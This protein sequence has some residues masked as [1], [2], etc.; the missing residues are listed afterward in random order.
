MSLQASLSHL[1]DIKSKSAKRVKLILKSADWNLLKAIS[2][3]AFNIVQGN[4]DLTTSF[5]R[6]LKK[7]ARI[8]N[9]LGDTRVSLAVKKKLLSSTRQ[10]S[11]ILK[12]MIKSVKWLNE[13]L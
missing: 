8:I 7:Y 2:E 12:L 11:T 9:R 13:W 5:K 4:V 10:I 1:K 6:R 3:I